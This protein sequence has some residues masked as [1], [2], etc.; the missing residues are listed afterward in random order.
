MK[1][2]KPEPGEW[3]RPIKVGYKLRCCDCDLVHKVDFKIIDGR[4][5]LRAFRDERAT[6]A[7]R[8]KK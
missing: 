1:Y 4:I 7:C 2:D 8:R 5:C 3:I 6:A